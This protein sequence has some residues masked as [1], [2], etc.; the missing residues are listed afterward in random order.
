MTTY[1][2]TTQPDVQRVVETLRTQYGEFSLAMLY[3]DDGLSPAGG[4]NLIVAAP[5]TDALGKAE[6]TGVVV[7]ALSKGLSLENKH[8]ISRV[9]VLPTREPFVRDLTFL[10]RITSPGSGQ[11]VQNISAGGIPIDAAYIFYSRGE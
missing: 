7:R 1:A 2:E 8:A 5:W 10:Y 3:S 11:W 6:A 9:T 4:W